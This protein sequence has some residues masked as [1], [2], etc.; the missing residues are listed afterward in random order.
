[1]YVST[2]KGGATGQYTYV[3][4]ME[5]YRDENGKVKHKV[6]QNLGR[7]DI[8]SQS[9]PNYLENLKKKYQ[10]DYAE[11]NRLQSLNRLAQ[12]QNLLSFDNNSSAGAPLPL[13]QYGHYLLKKIWDDHLHLDR[14]FKDIQHRQTKAKFD[15]NAVVS[16]LCFLKILDPHS[17]FY[18]F[19]DQDGFLGAPVQGIGLDSYYN[20]YD[21][22][23]EHKDSIMK[24]FNRS[25][26]NQLGKTKA[27]LI[28]YDVTNVYFET[29]L[30]D[31]ECGRQQMDFQD[32]LQ[33]EVQLAYESGELDAAC[34]DK[35]GR[36]VPGQKT[37]DFIK[38]IQAQKIEYLRMRG[39]SKEH[40]FDLPLTSI[41]LVINEEGIPIDFYVYAGNAFEFKTMA[42]SI[43]SL[44]QKY[45]VK[46]SIV[47]ADRGLNSAANLKMLQSNDLGFLMAQKVSNLDQKTTKAMF[48][49]EGYVP[50]IRQG[51]EVARFKVV[52]DWIKKGKRKAE[53]TKCTLVLTF[54]K[55]RQKRDLAVLEVWKQLVLKKQ[56]QGIKVKPKSSGWASIAKTSEK[57]EARIEGIDE[58]TFEAKRRLAGYAA[59]VY[60]NAPN[61]QDNDAVP[62]GRLAA[63][64]HELNQIES[65]FRIMKSHLGLR[66]MYVRN[67]NHIKGHILICVIALGI[68][69]L[70]QWKLNKSGT[71]LTI[72][73]IIRALNSATTVPI[74]SGDEL[75][76]LQCSRPQNIRK[77]LERLSQEELKAELAKRRKQ[78]N[79]LEI[80]FKTVGL[81]PPARLVN[82]KEM[83]RCLGV[84]LTTEEAIPE[85][86]KDML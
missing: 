65:C 13:L 30:T 3:R 67:S 62:D 31:L 56:A 69:K 14:K 82:L 58:E 42:A 24:F 79:Q 28:F 4:L 85:L 21:Y 81:V 74:K 72:S 37:D 73:E 12:V 1:M 78:P 46:E 27:T 26:N 40:R 47:V 50:I 6:V 86:I 53:D 36:L 8:L 19:G 49:P 29:A 51:E 77:G 44:K 64:Y 10:E 54:D 60:K 41:A 33:E 57:T 35:E 80:L 55:K 75:M 66:P 20:S 22:L 52:K 45:N 16:Y 15:L 71:P 25:I 59:L 76:F 43:E 17:V 2:C 83:G 32:R 11:K 34:F 70:L 9:D 39:P 38:K 48:D 84:R 68:L 7:L 63:A 5:S 18:S 23:F 61:C